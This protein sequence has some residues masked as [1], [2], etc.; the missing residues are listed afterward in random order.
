MGVSGCGKSSVAQAIA[1]QLNYQFI[2]ADDFHSQANQDHMAS[3]LALTDA[4]REPW[5][6]SL[7]SRLRESAKARQS[8]VMSFSG[9]RHQHRAAIRDLPF[10]SLFIHLEGTKSLIAKRINARS[11]HFM[12]VGLLDS[13]FN[14]LE[15]TS[16]NEN[17]ISINIEQN[18][19]CVVAEAM[20]AA[21]QIIKK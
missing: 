11:N 10:N 1:E 14:A 21:S 19:E 9:L 12:P 18:L 20:A 6:A 17:I 2:E 7:R 16:E 4:M 3:G 15:P 13:Q 8:C 5:I